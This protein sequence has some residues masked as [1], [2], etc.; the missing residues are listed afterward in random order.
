MVLKVYLTFHYLKLHHFRKPEM[1]IPKTNVD[2]QVA[3]PGL[4]LQ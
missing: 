1:L 2:S 4:F 3:V